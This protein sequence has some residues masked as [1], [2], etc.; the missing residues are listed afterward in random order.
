MP[1]RDVPAPEAGPNEVVIDVKA[2]GICGSDVHGYTGSTGR[3]TDGVFHRGGALVIE[4]FHGV[5]FQTS[6]MA[7]TMVRFSGIWALGGS[8]SIMGRSLAVYMR[9]RGENSN[10][11]DG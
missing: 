9:V 6:R 2:V 7:S 1:L 5:S 3:R 8:I 4:R 11:S 10:I